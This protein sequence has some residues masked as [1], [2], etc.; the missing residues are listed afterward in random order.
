MIERLC[1]LPVILALGACT[2]DR[3]ACE[4]AGHCVIDPLDCDAEQTLD[5]VEAV[6]ADFASAACARTNPNLQ[7][8][9]DVPAGRCVAIDVRTD[10]AWASCA[11]D[12]DCRPRTA[13][14]CSCNADVSLDNLIAVG[15]G[16]PNEGARLCICEGC[17]EGGGCAGCDTMV[18]EAA[19][20]VCDDGFC[21]LVLE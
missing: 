9:C 2:S 4:V 19:S 16:F 5:N 14:C 3:A 13:D 17:A 6:H 1:L 7:A 21:A 15:P 18:P 10:E 20:A 8:R 12:D 11:T